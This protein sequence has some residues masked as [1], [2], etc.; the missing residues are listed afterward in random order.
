MYYATLVYR[1]KLDISIE[2]YLVLIKKLV[3]P[4]L[5]QMDPFQIFVFDADKISLEIKCAGLSN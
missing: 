3:Q 1:S 4:A 2:K 5:T